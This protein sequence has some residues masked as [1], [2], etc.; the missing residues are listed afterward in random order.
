MC[1]YR[2]FSH[3]FW[4]SL[5]CAID[6]YIPKEYNTF[7]NSLFCAGDLDALSIENQLLFYMESLQCT[8]KAT[9]SPLVNTFAF[10]LQTVS[11][12]IRSILRQKGELW[13]SRNNRRNESTYNLKPK[14]QGRHCVLLGIHSFNFEIPEVQKLN[15]I[16]VGKILFFLFKQ[17]WDI[18]LKK[19]RFLYALFWSFLLKKYRWGASI[20]MWTYYWLSWLPNSKC[21]A[22]YINN[23]FKIMLSNDCRH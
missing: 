12:L 5:N 13:D 14:I 1:V 21:I 4:W 22:K 16:N 19:K 20:F 2:H 15:F 11:Q 10:L 3:H 9:I 8:S 18:N 17:H 7:L 23:A 6:G